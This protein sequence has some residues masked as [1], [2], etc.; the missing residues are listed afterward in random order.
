MATFYLLILGW[1]VVSI[2]A[3]ALQR[4]VRRVREQ[5]EEE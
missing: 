2:I 5:G 1:A 3:I 4:T